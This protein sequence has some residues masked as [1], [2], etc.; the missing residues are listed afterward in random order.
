MF[1]MF[2]IKVLCLGAGGLEKD[3]GWYEPGRSRVGYIDLW[4]CKGEV[5]VG[6]CG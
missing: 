1:V 4:L 2:V 5:M 3:G 6:K